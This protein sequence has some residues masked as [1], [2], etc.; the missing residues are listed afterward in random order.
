MRKPHNTA[1]LTQERLKQVFH[2]DPE[3]GIFTRILRTGPTG[4]PGDVMAPRA[5]NKGYVRFSV[6]H[7]LHFAQRLAWLYM[8]GKWPEHDIDHK[9]RNPAN[10][11]W[12]NLREATFKQNRENLGLNSNNT[13][14]FRGVSWFRPTGKWWARIGHNGKRV[15]LGHYKDLLSAVAARMAAERAMYTH[16]P[17]LRE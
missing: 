7:H 14:G 17:L 6:D 12:L 1:G 4:R 2:Y 9:D 10:N 11:R 8:T 13:S 15:S 5:S 3:T 16:S